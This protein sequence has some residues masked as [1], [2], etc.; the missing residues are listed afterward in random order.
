MR[1]GKVKENVLKRSVL[2]Q[3][4][5][6]S[7]YGSPALGEDAGIFSVPENSM[8]SIALNVNPVEGWTLAGARAIYGAVN[9][10]AAAKARPEAAAVS[11]LMPE[12]TEE[13]DLKAL[14]KDLDWFCKE[15][16]ILLLAG[17]TAVSPFVNNLVLS[18]TA[19]GICDK[20]ETDNR[21]VPDLDLVVAGTIGREGASLIAADRKEQLS[22]RYAASYIETAMHLFDHASMRT[23]AKALKEAGAVKIHDIREGGIFAGFWEMA[24]AG[25]VGLDI[26]LKKIPVKQH[27]IE[28]CEFYNLNPYML[29]SGGC[30]LAACPDGQ[31]AVKLLLENGTEA[32]VVGRTTG[33]NQRI[34]RY[35]DEIRFLEPPKSDEYY[36]MAAMQTEVSSGE[37]KIDE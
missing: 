11:I 17:H 36:K 3:L 33:E 23:A 29:L 1:P 35:D 16:D 27:T 2:R 19:L 14:M 30:L 18:V 32:A 24:A 31:K 28:V 15:E 7:S 22:A 10:L 9:S 6:R 25:K 26:D 13:K 37:T 8:Y 34:I 12:K 20:K 5:K 21:M 4:H